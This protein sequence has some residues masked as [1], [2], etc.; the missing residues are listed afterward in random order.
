[1]LN[2]STA[3]GGALLSVLLVLP[4]QKSAQEAPADTLSNLPCQ[5]LE[6]LFYQEI[7][8]NVYDDLPDQV[9]SWVLRLDT[10]CEMGEPMGR[11]QILASIWDGNFQEIVY[12]YQVISWLV[13]RY[14]PEKQPESESERAHF[15]AFTVEFAN[16]MLPHTTEGSL[17][18]FY[19]LYYTGQ[20]EAAWELLQSDAL[21][22]TWL[23]YYYDDEVRNLHRAS[24]P[25]L[26]GL[27][28]G[29]WWPR[30]NLAF[31]GPKQLA[32]ASLT[33]HTNWGFWR[34]VVEWRLGRSDEPYFV[35][36]EGVTGYS[37]RWDALL[38]AGEIGLKA[39]QAGRHQGDVFLGL[40]LDLVKPFK[41][42]EI[43]PAGFN[44]SLG[45]SY[46]LYMSRTERWYLQTDGRYEV[47]GDHNTDGDN[48]GGRAYSLRA[49]IGLAL[50]KSPQPRLKALG[51]DY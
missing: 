36:E 16:Q 49:G 39:W 46:R 29:R 51:V 30:E 37:D 25:Y 9:F 22:D 11:T 32:G 50:G 13:D 43:T 17:E 7:P 42:E 28:Y 21:T 40:G 1:V 4:N 47:I 23:R 19:C 14:D 6:K 3:L 35:S 34:F 31:V 38:I 18:Q 5:E 2:R 48:L 24:E 33:Q 26:L 41:A 44:V 12:G 10:E 15:D 8:R 27:H 20:T 45:V